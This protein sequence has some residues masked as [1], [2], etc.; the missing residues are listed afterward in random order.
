MSTTS[1]I[2][3]SHQTFAGARYQIKDQE[4]TES[5]VSNLAHHSYMLR[6]FSDDCAVGDELVDQKNGQASFPDRPTML[7]LSIVY[8]FHDR[9]LIF[10]RTAF[11]LPSV[12]THFAVMPA[13]GSRHPQTRI[14]LTMK[15]HF[16]HLRLSLNQ[17]HI[18][19]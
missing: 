6:A 17:Y 16:L 18:D 13:E 15:A 12:P 1:P 10:I 8:P 19:N 5:T 3:L 2:D 14:L 11:L 7:Q 9:C 4:D